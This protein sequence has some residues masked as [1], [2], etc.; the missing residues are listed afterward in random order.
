MELGGKASAVVLDDADVQ[1][2]GQQCA[3]GSFLHSGQI[4][5]ST[6]RILV[7]KD[8]KPE[9]VQ[10][11][12]SA[13]E[14]IFGA[15]EAPVLINA[16][17]AQKNKDLVSKAVKQGANVLYG[18][19]EKQELHPETKEESNT[20][21]RPIIVDGVSKDM[22]LYYAESFGPSVSLIEI[23]SDEEAI[24]IANDTEYGLS[25]AIFTE[26]LARGIRIAKQIESGY[27]RP[28]SF[29]SPVLVKARNAD[30]SAV[31]SI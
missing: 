13:V 16:A 21:L 7:H 29:R 2:A 18:D 20:R 9:F 5:M 17:G 24:Q 23:S 8:I 11:F 14:N 12:T 25:G 22:D 30:C 15:S 4:C 3:L 28:E 6:E 19:Y 31:L 26:N 10:A 27:V 1:K